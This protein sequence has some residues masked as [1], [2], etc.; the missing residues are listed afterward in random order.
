MNRKS[1][2]LLLVVFCATHL[3]SQTLLPPQSVTASDGEYPEYVKVT[4]QTLGNGTEYQVF[5][6]ESP[7]PQRMKPISSWQKSAVLQDRNHLIPDRRYYY[8]VKAQ[9]GQ[10]KSNFSVADVGY[11]RSSASSNDSTLSSSKSKDFED[12]NLAISLQAIER[13]TVSARDS[14]FVAYVAVNKKQQAMNQVELRFYLSKDST[15]DAN[16]PLLGTIKLDKLEPL[17]S[18]R[19]AVRLKASKNTAA[20]A[21]C[22]VMVSYREHGSG[23]MLQTFKKVMIR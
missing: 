14:F 11:I 19:G 15:P 13:D 6:G 20:G 3:F 9:Y 12:E 8:R 22:L 5:R 16:T 4:W 2:L 21:Y 18:Q 1:L 23:K 17:S 10:I 7:E